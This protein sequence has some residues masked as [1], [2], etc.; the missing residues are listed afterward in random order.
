MPSMWAMHCPKI[1]M[2]ENELVIASP[3]SF[4]SSIMQI[5]SVFGSFAL[6]C[7]I[8]PC[9]LQE[10]TMWQMSGYLFRA[11]S[12]TAT[13][14]ELSPDRKRNPQIFPSRQDHLFHVSK[15]VRAWHRDHFAL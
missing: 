7:N 12:N 6:S 14:S 4:A 11:F 5:P 13:P 15:Q 10:I 2:F 3:R 8:R 1:T 9:G